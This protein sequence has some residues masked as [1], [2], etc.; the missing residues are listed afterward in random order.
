M[1]VAGFGNPVAAD[2]A[3]FVTEGMRGA[4]VIADEKT[5]DG[6]LRHPSFAGDGRMSSAPAPDTTGANTDAWIA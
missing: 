4:V 5:S 1:L 3:A 6:L 2:Y